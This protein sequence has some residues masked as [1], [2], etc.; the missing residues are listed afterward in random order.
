MM[1]V[2]PS[3]GLFSSRRRKRPT[4]EEKY[5]AAVHPEL[6]RPERVEGSKGRLKMPFAH[7]L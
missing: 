5:Y 3:V 7:V 4:K 6:A 1:N 2:I